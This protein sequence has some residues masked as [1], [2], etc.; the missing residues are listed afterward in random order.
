MKYQMWSIRFHVYSSV[1]AIIVQRYALVFFL[2]FFS[3]FF[4]LSAAC[5]KWMQW[6]WDSYSESHYLGFLGCKQICL[7]TLWQCWACSVCHAASRSAR[8]ARAE[9]SASREGQEGPEIRCLLGKL[10]L[11]SLGLW[12]NRPEIVS[13]MWWSS[14][15]ISRPCLQEGRIWFCELSNRPC[16]Q[17]KWGVVGLARPRGFLKCGGTGFNLSPWAFKGKLSVLWE[18]MRESS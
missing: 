1:P 9:P 3:S 5:T 11:K 13:A 7:E 8:D 10:L 17:W 4:V 12:A 2:F 6:R 18:K 14:C 15:N 16:C